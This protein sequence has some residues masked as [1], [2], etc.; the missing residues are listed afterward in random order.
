M[1]TMTGFLS[2]VVDWLREGYPAGIP[3][4]DTIP[5]LALLRRRLTD[6]EVAE[7]ATELRASGLLPADPDAAVGSTHIGAEITKVTDELPLP[8]DI[9]RVAEHL[10][11]RGF[12]A[13]D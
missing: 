12:P 5:V 7:I 10:L 4:Q 3:A 9:Q 1:A 8:G 2:R 11:F 6:S 13:H